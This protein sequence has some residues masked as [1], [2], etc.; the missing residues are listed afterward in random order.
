MSPVSLSSIPSPDEIASV[1]ASATTSALLAAGDVAAQ[2]RPNPINVINPF[3]DQILAQVPCLLESDLRLAIDRAQ[4]GLDFLSALSGFERARLLR[5]WQDKVGQNHRR[6]AILLSLENGKP[7]A[8]AVTEISNVMAFL[9]WF[10]AEAER[11][12]GFLAQHEQPGRHIAITHEPVG[13]VGAISPWNFPSGMIARK[14]APALAAGCPVLVKP[15]EL[16]PLSALALVALGHEAGFPKTTLQVV[17]GV[18]EQIGGLF[19]HHPKVAKISFTGSTPVGRWLAEQSG[20]RLKRL[21]LELGGAA[22]V[23]VGQDADLDLTVREL[24]AAKFRNAGQTCVSPN[25]VYVARSIL[26]DLTERLKVA[27]GTLRVG[28]PLDPQTR[29]GPLISAQGRD[30]ALRHIKA[31]IDSGSRLHFGGTPSPLF[32]NCLLPTLLVGGDDRLL[33][34]EETFGPVLALFAFDT[35]QDAVHRAND[36]DYGLAAYGF[37]KDLNRAHTY[38]RQIRA[39]MVAINSGSISH[40]ASPFGGIGQS[41][42]GRE[43]SILGLKEYQNVKTSCFVP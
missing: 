38:A 10:A 14:L 27:L 42:Y 16:T 37:T 19:A 29:L 43:G 3:N 1:L 5:A 24:I 26:S 25:R 39:G 40:V 18:P 7:L 34:R 30:K 20:P 12:G 11:D 41:G 4:E 32:P 17:L 8:E 9:G 36:S 21:S 35:D 15:S 6:L 23:I 33:C 13:I 22:P 2:D 28:D 31:L